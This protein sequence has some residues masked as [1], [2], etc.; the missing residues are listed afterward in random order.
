MA[1]SNRLGGVMAKPD[2]IT[3]NPEIAYEWLMQG[4]LLA[5]PTESVWGLGCNAFDKKAVDE[6]LI[7]KNRPVHKGLIV[8]T[9]NDLVVQDFF[10]TLPQTR[11]DEIIT[12]WQT[13]HHTGQASTWLF[14]IAD[15]IHIPSNVRGEHQS[16]AIRVINHAKVGKLCELLINDD[17][18]FGFLVSTSCNLNG[19]PPA[20]DF[21]TAYA[22]FG[23]KVGYLLGETLNFDKPSQ[24]KNAKTGELVRF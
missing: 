21:K 20:K 2:F 6:L 7:L 8:L 5:Y 14:D 10:K 15:E 16:L 1:L 17:N 4:K 19:E 13:A 3:D 18:C 12:S 23:N 9:A 11:Q 24:I 22:Y